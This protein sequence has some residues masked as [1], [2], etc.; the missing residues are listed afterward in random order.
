MPLRAFRPCKK[1]GCIKLTRDSNGYCLDHVHSE[2]E[3][4]TEYKRNRTDKKEQSFYASTAW[5]GARS[6]ALIRDHGLCQY[7]LRA[8]KV[9][10]ADV[11]HH[12]VEIKA[13]WS[14]RLVLVNLVSLCHGC[15]QRVHR[16][17]E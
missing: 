7:C 1:V 12:I 17:K 16:G 14:L 9:T 3:N 13:N 8:S 10:L 6:Q 2:R 11:V 4:H 5:L 15:H